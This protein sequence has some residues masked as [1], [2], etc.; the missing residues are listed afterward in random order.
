MAILFAQKKIKL[1]PNAE[2]YGQQGRAW[3]A[4][5]ELDGT[6]PDDLRRAHVEEQALKRHGS[7]CLRRLIME[8]MFNT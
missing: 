1:F 3:L 4:G 2:P 7:L 8:E 5:H 6:G